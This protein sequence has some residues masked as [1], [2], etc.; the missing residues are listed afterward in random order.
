MHGLVTSFWCIFTV[1]RSIGVVAGVEG[2]VGGRSRPAVTEHNEA[3]V[4]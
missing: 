1:V 4:W 2:E 3:N